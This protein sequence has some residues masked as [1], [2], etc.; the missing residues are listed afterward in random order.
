MKFYLLAKAYNLYGGHITL[1]LIPDFLLMDA[2]QFGPAIR[3]LTLTLHFETSHFRGHRSFAEA[4]VQFHADRAK[5]PTTVFRRN[6]ESAAIDYPS[7]LMDGS[8]WTRKSKL[9]LSVFL[10]GVDETLTALSLLGARIKP[11]DDFAFNEFMAFCHSR[12][13]S[14]PTSNE[15]LRSLA[16][17][18]AQREEAI[19]RSMTEWEILDIEWRGFHRDARQILDSPFFWEQSNY[20]AP[21]GND[22]GAD[23]LRDYRTWL[24]RNRSRDPM[25]F[26]REWIQG[27]GLGME[28]Q[29]P[30]ALNLLD[31]AA[32]AVAFAEFK[33]QGTCATS[34]AQ[35]ALMAI[36]RM[37]RDAILAVTW[38][39]RDR[40]L[41][42]LELM[43]TKLMDAI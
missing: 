5:L 21:H 22:T 31:E 9:S 10:A 17:E 43:Q 34:A 19:R 39:H 6:R 38:A 29:D 4:Y 25:D 23:V 11:T 28:T 42:T 26:L 33:L 8:K 41:Q 35:L 32:L 30:I 12:K 15:A 20:L 14:L 2:P 7:D 16:L 27:T 37:R 40:R 13:A 1:S 24:L 36:D 18:I 3:E